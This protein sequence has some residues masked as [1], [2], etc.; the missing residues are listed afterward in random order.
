MAAG[1][2]GTDNDARANYPSNYDLNNNV[3]VAATDHNDA[4]ASFSQYGATTVDLGAP[5]V[6]TLST[7]PGGGYGVKSGTSMATPHVAGAATLIASAY[8][9]I[10]NEDLIARLYGGVDQVASLEGKTA[11][12]GRLNVNNSLLMELPAQA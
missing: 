9:E 10:S 12:G 1:N 4:L 6:R 5:G 3:A 11:T 7:V 8:P 2:S